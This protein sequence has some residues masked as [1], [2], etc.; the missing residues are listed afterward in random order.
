MKKAEIV[1]GIITNI[2]VVDPDNIPDWCATWPEAVGDVSIGWIYSNG[3]FIEPEPKQPTYEEQR[4]ARKK[5][6]IEEADPLFFK[7]QRGEA[8]ME[9]WEAKIEEIKARYPYP[10]EI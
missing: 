9:E 2:I 8:T 5:A 4:E 3:E 7:A 6:Y 10:E 1:K